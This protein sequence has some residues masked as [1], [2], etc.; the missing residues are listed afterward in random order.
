MKRR[1]SHPLLEEIISMLTVF[2]HSY[3]IICVDDGLKDQSYEILRELSRKINALDVIRFRRNF[4][5]P[6][7][8]QA[9][10]DAF[11]DGG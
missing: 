7:A 2:G 9:G 8:L 1:I 3:E 10:F 4:G 6:A 5:Q 11:R